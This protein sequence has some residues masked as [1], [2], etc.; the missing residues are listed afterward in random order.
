[1]NVNITIRLIEVIYRLFVIIK[2][3]VLNVLTLDLLFV[4]LI[5]FLNLL[6][7]RNS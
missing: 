5:A 6:T 3:L 2:K 4:I 1:M 7:E